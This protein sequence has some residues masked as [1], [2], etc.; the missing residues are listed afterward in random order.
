MFPDGAPTFTLILFYVTVP[1]W[2]LSGG[3]AEVRRCRRHSSAV[4]VE[5]GFN[6]SELLEARNNEGNG[7]TKGQDKGKTDAQSQISINKIRK[8]LKKR[9]E[10]E[11]GDVHQPSSSRFIL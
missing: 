4:L 10:E 11:K 8:T 6:N 9:P 2:S 5:G 3:P 1:H 7:E